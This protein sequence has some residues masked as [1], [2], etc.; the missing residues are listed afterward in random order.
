MRIGRKVEIDTLAATH[1]DTLQHIATHEVR[2]E[3]GRENGD[4]EG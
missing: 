3:I 4:R 1:C 2:R